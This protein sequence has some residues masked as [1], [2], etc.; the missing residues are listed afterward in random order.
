LLHSVAKVLTDLSGVRVFERV[1]RDIGR[2]SENAS[3]FPD[4]RG[5]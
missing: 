5:L 2:W 3:S 4:L 1:W